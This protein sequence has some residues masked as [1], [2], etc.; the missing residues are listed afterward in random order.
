MLLC[1]V[2][3][4]VIENAFSLQKARV[5]GLLLFGRAGFYE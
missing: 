4:L 2:L 1:V 3:S 5:F